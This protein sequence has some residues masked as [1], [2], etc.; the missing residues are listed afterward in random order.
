[1]L[2]ARPVESYFSPDLIPLDS[3]LFGYL[4]DCVRSNSLHNLN[5][6]QAEITHGVHNITEEMLQNVFDS[7]RR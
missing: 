3:F 6:L 4:K 2:Y 1:M 5:E 7:M